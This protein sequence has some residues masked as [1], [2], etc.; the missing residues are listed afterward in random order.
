LL[1]QIP[2]TES[3]IEIADDGVSIKKDD[4]K[5]VVNPYDEFAV[6]EALQIRDK[7][8]GT[9]TILSV[10]SQQAVDAIRTALAMGA[11]KGVLIDEPAAET[12]DALG[13]AKIIT[14]A[15]KDIPYDL[16]IAGQRAVDDDNA[17]VAQAVAE[18]LQI[19]HISLVVKEEINDGKIQCQRTIEGGTLTY[20]A[21]LPA[22]FTTQRGLN[23]PRFASLPGIMKAKK[24]PLD[25]KTTADIG[26]DTA[27]DCKPLSRITSMK[28]P[29]QRTGG[30][31]I[32][33][34]SVEAKVTELVKALH[35]EAKVI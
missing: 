31:V 15:L 2:A 28:L 4:I 10:G 32:Q 30:R 27:A 16:I 7:Q 18:F 33:G 14:A 13:I 35:E 8:G 20:E 9:V 26:I 11:D 24:K 1:K 29:L 34:D 19:P 21:P 23:E 12:F 3:I 6:E 22:L 17:Q 25:I 5:W